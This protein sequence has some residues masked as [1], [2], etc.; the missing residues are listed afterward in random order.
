M[1]LLKNVA[2]ITPKSDIVL[3]VN[4]MTFL[5]H[6]LMMNYGYHWSCLE[7]DMVCYVQVLTAHNFDN[8]Q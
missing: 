2:G 3:T 8:I 7:S 5:K 1:L 4:E 6:H